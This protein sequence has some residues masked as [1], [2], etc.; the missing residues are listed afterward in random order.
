M[1]I[2]GLNIVFL[3][4]LFCVQLYAGRNDSLIR[5]ATNLTVD[6]NLLVEQSLYFEAEEKIMTSI[7]IWDSINREHEYEFYPYYSLG[8]LYREMGFYEKSIDAYN[9][10]ERLLQKSKSN[11]SFLY[12][13][14]YNAIANYYLFT[15]DY[16]K[17]LNYFEYALSKNSRGRESMQIYVSSLHGVAQVYYYTNRLTEAIL[18]SLREI[19]ISKENNIDATNSYVILANSYIK[20][21]NYDAAL[22]ILNNLKTTL[23]NSTKLFE[24]DAY[25]LKIYIELEQFDKAAQIIQNNQNK[26]N[27]LYT[28]HDSWNIYFSFIQG[29]Y[30]YKRSQKE[31]DFQLKE[32][33]L[34][35]AIEIF[36]QALINNS[37]DPDGDIPYLDNE[38]GDFVTPTQVSEIFVHRAKA[39]AALFELKGSYEPES[40]ALLEEALK[41]YQA[42]INFTYELKVSL[43]DEESKLLLT[44]NQSDTY[45]EAFKIAHDLYHFTGSEKYKNKLFEIA[46]QSKSSTFLSSLN[47]VQALNFGGIPDSI[48]QKEKNIKQQLTNYK[49]LIFNADV[50]NTTDSILLAQWESNL[51]KSEKEYDDLM[52][53]LERKYKDYYNFKYKKS[54]IKPGNIRNTLNSNQVLL[55]YLIDE[56]IYKND[57]GIVYVLKIT[58]HDFEIIE[59]PIGYSYIENLNTL[60]QILSSRNVANTN[61]QDYIDYVESAYGLYEDL[62]EGVID[63]N[64]ENECIVV[65]D[66]KM[67]YI[68]LDALISEYPDTSVMNFRDLS[69]LIYDYNFS[70]SYSS[71]LHF[72]YFKSKSSVKN[73]VLAFAP[74][75]HGNVFDLNKE[76]YEV[77]QNEL[78]QTLRPL[79][80]AQLEVENLKEKYKC[81]AYTNEHA[82]E[83]IF[84]ETSEKYD[85]LH[86]AMHT[87][88]NDSLPMFS[89]LIFS[90]NGDS[91]NDGYLN[92]QEIYNMKFKARL[93]VLSA[94]NTGSGKFRNGEGVMSLARAFLYA[95]CPSIVMTLWEVEDKSSSNLINS[96]YDELY[97]GVSKSEAL[98]KA[99]QNHIKN[100]DQLRAH[101]Y[102]WSGYI[103]IGNQSPIKLNNG[104]IYFTIILLAITGFLVFVG[105]KIFTRKED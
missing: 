29:L 37:M 92:T 19:S 57:S 60:H 33:H 93:A 9:Y 38:E 72:N 78:F 88:I 66:D 69:Y 41:T 52:Y 34:L 90:T 48:L 68:P 46:E 35:N 86:L 97:Q 102:F 3:G 16:N 1:S 61:K 49:Q 36:N 45:V 103:V 64:G 10:A 51:F 21:H 84:K 82:T 26:V 42:V 28:K 77:R 27:E 75:Y 101:P 65:P 12:C 4:V 71:T 100:A 83:T 30:Y 7:Q 59:K 76:A 58:D 13:G 6:G 98:R 24:N 87:V 80:G 79:P 74:T 5:V 14:L 89:K 44:E 8:R 56:P 105:I 50:K 73:E 11:N 2:K 40:L 25:L 43:K 95:G 55:E 54:T 62:I 96:F 85:I 91:L 15:G 104:S 63:P 39:L 20:Q 67:A 17:S 53:L 22:D 99:K 31:P 18:A 81:K 70:Y 23:T 32:K 94:C 47:D